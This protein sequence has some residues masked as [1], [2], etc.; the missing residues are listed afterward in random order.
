MVLSKAN[1]QLL[2][3]QVTRAK[4]NHRGSQFKIFSIS[5]NQVQMTFKRKAEWLAAC[6]E[7][8]QSNRQRVS[9]IDQYKQNVHTLTY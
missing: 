1:F 3:N 6:E 2:K 5:K 8:F 4:V 9:V 7:N